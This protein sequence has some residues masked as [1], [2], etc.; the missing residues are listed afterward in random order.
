M[1]AASV[2]LL[3]EGLKLLF[4]GMTTVFAFLA[5]LVGALL[6]LSSLVARLEARTQ[7]VE[8]RVPRGSGTAAPNDAQDPR[9]IAAIAAAIGVYRNRRRPL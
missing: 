9:R 8:G 1:D 3:A 4:I 6:V 2:D 7:P 5:L